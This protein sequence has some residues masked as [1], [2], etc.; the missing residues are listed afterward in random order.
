MKDNSNDIKQAE[1]LFDFIKNSPSCYHVIANLKN[2]LNEQGFIELMENENWYIE[3][4]GKYYTTRGGSS[5]IVFYVPNKDYSNYQITAS[6]SDS[7]SFKIKENPEML[8]DGH[9]VELNVEK[10]GGMIC[11][12]WFDRPLSIAGRVV[13][14]DDN[15]S[16]FTEKLVNVDRNLVMIPN[17][18]I[19]MNRDVNNG[20]TYNAQKDMIPILGEASAKNT[21]YEIIAESAGVAKENIVATDLFL[22]NRVEPCV[23]GA[24][25]EFI[26]STKLDDL[27]CA[28]TTIKGFIN[29]I[30]YNNKSVSVCC[31]F[32]N[33]EVGSGTKQGANST[34]LSDVLERINESCCRTRQQYMMAIADSFMISADNAHAIH[35]H[36]QDKADPTNRP[37]MN[38]GIVIKYNANQKYTTDAISA[39]IFKGI[40]NKA[41]V[42][43]QSYVNRS[44]IAG[45][46]TLGNISNSHV[47]LNTVDIGLAQLAMHSPYETAGI[48]DIA[49]MI[50]AITQFYKTNIH[51]DKDGNY[52]F[53]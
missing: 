40:C 15:M 16:N 34:F 9:Y 38:D 5:I 1:E 11:S 10:Y 13:A 28:Y 47:S 26:S 50:K 29:G 37:Y 24:N 49:Y 18:A 42:P 8:T 3:N 51:K 53:L 4:A 20:Y 46:S 35:P 23:W 30:S 27:E 14:A 19:H 52:K 31:V 32:D 12:P 7:P 48:K 33:E 2:M 44:D 22:Y 43:V 36:H 39:S 6:H 17:V 25:N 45:G 21:F 41:K